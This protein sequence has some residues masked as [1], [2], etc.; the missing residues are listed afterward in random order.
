MPGLSSRFSVLAAF[1]ALTGLAGAADQWT[2]FRGP[3]GTGH[4]DSVGLPSVWAEAK[5][6]AWKTRIHGRGWSSPVVLG[7]QVWLTTATPEGKELSVLALDRD[8]GHVLF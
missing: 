1:L 4:S 7:K 8:D 6:V 2:E 3:S 5:N